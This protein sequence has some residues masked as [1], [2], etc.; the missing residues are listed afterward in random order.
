MLCFNMLQQRY[1]WAVILDKAGD[2]PILDSE[3]SRESK[4]KTRMP[5]QARCIRLP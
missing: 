1:Q 5:L 4:S 3:I 2:L